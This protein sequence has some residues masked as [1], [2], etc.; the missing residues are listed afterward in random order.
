MAD[1][2]CPD[3]FGDLPG[4]SLLAGPVAVDRGV[5]AGIGE[6]VSCLAQDDVDAGVGRPDEGREKFR[7]G[8]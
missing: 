6:F 2:G 5:A 4:A 8:G 7:R 3:R 1:E